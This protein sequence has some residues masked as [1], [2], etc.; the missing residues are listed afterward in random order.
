MGF[1]EDIDKMKNNCRKLEIET[2]YEELV[3]RSDDD[4]ARRVCEADDAYKTQLHKIED[5][6]ARHMDEFFAA[7]NDPV[8]SDRD[9]FEC[10]QSE[11]SRER[12]AACKCRQRK[13]AEAY[14]KQTRENRVNLAKHDEACAEL[15]RDIV[16]A[17]D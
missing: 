10:R 16:D 8:D 15:R 11:F 3:Q 13:A 5:A 9:K 6:C 4:R 14:Q 17:R 2:A 7:D 1:L 12:F